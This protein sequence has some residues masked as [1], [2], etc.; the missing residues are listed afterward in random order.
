MKWCINWRKENETWI[1][2]DRM[3]KCIVRNT[4]EIVFV[5]I[6]VKPQSMERSN[7]R[8]AHGE[9][10]EI[11]YETIPM[12]LEEVE[13][14]VQAPRSKQIAGTRTNID[15][16]AKLPKATRSTIEIKLPK[17]KKLYIEGNLIDADIESDPNMDIFRSTIESQYLDGNYNSINIEVETKDFFSGEFKGHTV[18]Q[19]ALEIILLNRVKMK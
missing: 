19:Q 17:S 18:L 11:S 9:I 3:G 16:V 2:M 1:L 6:K 5:M 12:I 14:E 7:N 4:R 8:I 10:R 13:A 15:L